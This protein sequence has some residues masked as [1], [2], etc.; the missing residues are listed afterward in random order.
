MMVIVNLA[1][2][3]K[4]S[5]MMVIVNLAVKYEPKKEMMYEYEYEQEKIA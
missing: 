1:Q 5:H 4:S 3:R 2:A